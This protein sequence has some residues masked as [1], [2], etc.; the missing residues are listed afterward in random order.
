MVSSQT[1]VR[2]VKSTKIT[3][4]V[5]GEECQVR[6]PG[7]CNFNPETVIPAHINGGGMG[8]KMPDFLIAHAC[9]CCHAVLDGQVPSEFSRE[10]L[11][12]WHW[13]AVGRTQIILHHKGLLV[14]A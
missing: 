5:K 14:A 7:V 6:I 2:R 4:S 11:D 13:E 10:Q 1:K 3:R 12:L 8:T 9:C